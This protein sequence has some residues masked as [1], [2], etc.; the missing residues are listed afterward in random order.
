MD[1]YTALHISFDSATI[2]TKMCVLCCSAQNVDVFCFFAAF[3]SF[4]FF[5]KKVVKGPTRYGRTAA[6]RLIVQPYDE[7][8]DYYFLSFS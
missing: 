4:T 2:K 1:I 7:D 3:E 5:L 6:M 8:D